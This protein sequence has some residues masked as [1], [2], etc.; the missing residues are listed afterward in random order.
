MSEESA[1][2]MDVARQVLGG[3][4]VDA[5]VVADRHLI[6]LVSTGP[7]WG[8]LRLDTLTELADSLGVNEDQVEVW[9]VLGGRDGGDHV[10][11]TVDLCERTPIESPAARHRR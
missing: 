3:R 11:I 9:G 6:V 2:A 1:G 7:R 5:S 4:V 10:E 8:K